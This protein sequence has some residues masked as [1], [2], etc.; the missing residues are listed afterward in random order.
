MSY[1]SRASF[2]VMLPLEQR[3]LLAAVFPSANEQYLVE[4][5]NRARA[6]PAAEASRY[7]IALNEGVPS[8]ET[9]STSAKQPLAINPYITDAARQHSQ[10]MIDADIFSHTGSGGT[11]PHQRMI[12]AGYTFTGSYASGE[13]IAYNSSTGSINSTTGTGKNHE[14]LFVD[15]DYPNRGHRTNMLNES[16][17]EIG[18]GV[19]TG[20][21]NGWNAVMLTEDFGKTGTNVFL[22]GVA[23][24]DAVTKDNFYTVGEGLGG[25]TISAKPLTTTEIYTTTTWDSGGYSLALPAGTYTVTA[26][27]G[28][29]GGTVTYGNVVVG[30]SNVKRDFTPLN[31]DSFA[32]VIG[33]KLKVMGTA[34][35]DAISITYNGNS[36]QVSRNSTTTT[37]SGNGVTSIEIYGEDGDD[38][39]FIG[40]SVMGTYA[41]GGNGNDYLQGGDFN[42][43]LSGG[44]GKDRVFGG[45]GDDR[46]N[47]NGG[48]DRLNGEASKDRLYGGEGNDT[49]DGGSSTDRL[50]GDAGNNTYYGQGGD[51]YLYARNTLSD[52]L[53]GQ[54]GIDHAQVDNTDVIATIEDLIA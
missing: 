39:I 2:V 50:F 40:A 36:Y 42:D 16:Y 12:N 15:K 52:T 18:A 30:S 26:S 4:L 47:G 38:A 19:A 45:I 25:V 17:R 24:T 46:V 51:D 20:S 10:W 5:I 21:F 41:I 29:L 3:R 14:I 32:T 8:D 33:G 28:A 22:T 34:G 9:I 7:G 35:V 54:G 6:N 48:H 1:K 53:F 11:S 13:N 43:T 44:A 37:L 23:Y 27:G 49:L 31:L